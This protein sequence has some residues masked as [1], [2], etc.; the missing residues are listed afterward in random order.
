M[1]G[2]VGEDEERGE[3]RRLAWGYLLLVLVLVLVLVGGVLVG[4]V[5][6]VGKGSRAGDARRHGRR[7]TLEALEAAGGKNGKGT[8]HPPLFCA[9]HPH[10][11][12][13]MD[14]AQMWT[15]ESLSKKR[16]QGLHVHTAFFS[17]GGQTKVLTTP[18]YPPIPFPSFHTHTHTQTTHRASSTRPKRH[19]SARKRKKRG[20]SVSGFFFFSP[21]LTCT[22]SFGPRPPPHSRDM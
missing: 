10:Q 3:P 6:G 13:A 8:R 22:C 7:K 12:Q 18:P 9:T 21:L 14:E 5:L 16:W 17:Q 1:G 15:N 11:N 4:W 2:S 19:G 20:T